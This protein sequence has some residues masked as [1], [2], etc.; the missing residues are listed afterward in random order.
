MV[1]FLL[2]TAQRRDEAASL[3]HG[4]ILNGVW[5][6][7]ENKASR[8]HSI[9]LP[10]LAKTLVGQGD[11]RDYVFG[12]HTG[13]IGA[14]SKLKRMLDKASGVNDWRLH[15]LRRTAAT[16]MQEL[17]IRNEVVQAVLNHRCPASAASICAPNSK[18]RR[19][20]RWRCGRWR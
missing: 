4:H 18:R 17:G 7:M 3:R 11:A 13:K 5:R 20:T 1:R 10:P 9:P 14:F 12:G 6:Q 16:N 8:P 19:P 2:L 15:D